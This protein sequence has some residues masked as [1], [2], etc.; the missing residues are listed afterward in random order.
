MENQVIRLKDDYMILSNPRDRREVIV[1]DKKEEKIILKFNLGPQFEKVQLDFEAVLRHFVSFQSLSG[2]IE[3]KLAIKLLQTHPRLF[4]QAGFTSPALKEDYI[5]Y[6]LGGQ[7]VQNRFMKLTW[8]LKGRKPSSSGESVKPALPS[9]G[10]C[11][12]WG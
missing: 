12:H 1:L 8:D 5:Q 4:D 3:G 10:P 2:S 11:H 6:E 9:A 7:S